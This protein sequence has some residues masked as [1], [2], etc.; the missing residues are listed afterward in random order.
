MYIRVD[1]S[2][3]LSIKDV[4]IDQS[5]YTWSPITLNMGSYSD[6]R[7]FEM[8]TAQHPEYGQLLRP[9]KAYHSYH[10]EH[11]FGFGGHCDGFTTEK[12]IAIKSD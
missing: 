9:T 4:T 1:P 12:T 2:K 7:D 3:G 11:L 10:F 5:Q 8:E 6:S